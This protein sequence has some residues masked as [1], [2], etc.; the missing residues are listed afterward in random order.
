MTQPRPETIVVLDYGGQTAQ[1]IARRVREQGVFS[2]LVPWDI[3]TAELAAMDPRG[4]ILSGGP[5][6]V[7]DEG[8]PTLPAWVIESGRPVLGIC[9][10]MQLLAHELGGQVD[11]SAHR[12]FG[13]ADVTLDAEEA[14]FAGLP[15]TQTV[16][17]SHA[18]R[19]TGL[20]PGFRA[21]G[22]TTNSPL[23]VMGDP[24]HHRYAV[25]FHPEVV[26]TPH[27]AALL[28]NFVL[29]E[30][31]CRG[32]W[33]PAHFIESAVAAIREQVGDGQ[34]LVAISGGVDSSVMAALVHR[35]VGERMLALFLDHGLLR[36]G[37][38]D[39]VRALFADLGIPVR[40]VDVADTFLGNLAGVVDP[41]EKRRIIG[42]TFVRVFERE[43]AA[44]AGEYGFLA[45]GTL[46]PDVIESATSASKSAHKIKTHHNVGGLPEDLEFEIIEPL[47]YLFKDEV[48]AV[49]RELKLPEHLVTRQPFPGPGL[50]VRVLSDITPEAL[51]TL[52]AADRIVRHEIEGAR[53]ELGA[54]FPWQYFAVLTPVR[55]VG[56][57]G[58]QRTYGN[59][60][61]VRAVTSVDGM[62]ADW[63]RLPD[64]LLTR[65]ATRIVNEV[66]GV[67]RVVY[68]ITSKPP[69]T[70]EWE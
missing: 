16:W 27:G 24:V 2:E 28:R 10:G 67:N 42:H 20:P 33:T 46:Y 38:P 37:E 7:Y 48:R 15:R 18:D 8:A 29:G 54:G 51:D 30:C 68:D 41:E 64:S 55:S 13:L 22:H 62:T 23:A 60:V 50:A 61:G 4:F 21:L 47:R 17:M 11:P 34:V 3:S 25:Q 5:N 35:A 9:Y 19:V 66:P 56:V 44:A 39:E 58:D 70:I 43:A 65:I 32:D 49:G 57:M 12:E 31:G 26:H 53:E 40:M 59:L 14:V 52:R 6:S 45:Q 36:A 63:A 69:A 1:L